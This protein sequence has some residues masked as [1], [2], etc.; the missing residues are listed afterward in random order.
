MDIQVDSSPRQV[1]VHR[2]RSGQPIPPKTTINEM[3]FKH[4]KNRG[5]NTSSPQTSP[6]DLPCSAHQ[7]PRTWLITFTRWNANP[8]V[9]THKKTTSRRR[10]PARIAAR[11][12][13]FLKNNYQVKCKC[14]R[15]AE[16]GVVVL[17]GASIRAT[18]FCVDL[19]FV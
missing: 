15:G 19:F 1:Y 17:S 11:R 7:F 6:S 5:E 18:P 16:F 2:P 4:K 3:Y 10:W 12:V 9:R 13:A 8:R 14:A